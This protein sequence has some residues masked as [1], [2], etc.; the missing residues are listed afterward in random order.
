M[1]N[2]NWGD[3]GNKRTP[4][5]NQLGHLP[6]V[7]DYFNSVIYIYFLYFE[8]RRKDCGI[9][10]VSWRLTMELVGLEYCMFIILLLSEDL[11]ALD[12]LFESAMAAANGV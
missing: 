9:V 11:W 7:I 6:C 5:H 12:A 3:G 1:G 10:C 2:W 4:R 8:F